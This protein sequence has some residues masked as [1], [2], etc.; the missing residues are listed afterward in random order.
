MERETKQCPDCAE[1]VLVAARKCRYCG[2]RFDGR[3]SDSGSIVGFLDGRRSE[4]GSIVDS[5]LGRRRESRPNAT[6]DEFLDDWGVRLDDGEEVRFF[7]LAEADR[8]LGFLIVTSGRVMF[9]A[10]RPRAPHV[11][12][13]ET[14][15]GALTGAARLSRGRIVLSGPGVDHT[16]GLVKRSDAQPL[17]DWLATQL[18]GEGPSGS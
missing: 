7:V 5:L 11:K 18:A 16:L 10:Q 13:F 8:Q 3:R 1:Q 4:G 12:V 17:A 15:L 2:Y 6:I 14:P 9:F